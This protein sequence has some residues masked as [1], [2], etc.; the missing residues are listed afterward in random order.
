MN[1]LS[2]TLARIMKKITSINL[3]QLYRE[4]PGCSWIY[5]EGQG[6]CRFCMQKNNNLTKIIE[7]IPDDSERCEKCGEIVPPEHQTIG[8]EYQGE[9]E[10]SGSVYYLSGY[11]CPACGHHAEV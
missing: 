3:R 5:T 7:E 11:N 9:Q 10:R 2:F 6:I 1:P 4:C 8:I